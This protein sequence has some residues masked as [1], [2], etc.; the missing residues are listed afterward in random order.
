MG[1]SA[2]EAENNTDL[3]SVVLPLPFV[4]GLLALMHLTGNR[5]TESLRAALEGHQMVPTTLEPETPPLTVGSKRASS[6]PHDSDLMAE[7]L[8]Q[9]V[10]GATLPDLFAGCVDM[11]HDLDPSAIERLAGIKT[12]ARRYVARRSE[13]IHFKSPHLKT[14]KTKSGWWI[15]TNISKPQ[16]STSLRLLTNAANLTFGKDLIFP[17][18]L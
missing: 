3:V 18:Q 15:S 13:D 9:M 11:I 4:H 17:A 10:Q 8:G 7:I 6:V 5:V 12:H 14:M 2:V 16:C 1:G